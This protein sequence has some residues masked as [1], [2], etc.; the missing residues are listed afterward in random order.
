ME[1]HVSG[2]PSGPSNFSQTPLKKSPKFCS[3]RFSASYFIWVT[4]LINRRQ[5]KMCEIYPSYY[6]GI[7]L[8]S[9]MG[10]IQAVVVALCMERD[11]SR[12]KLGW[13]IRLLTVFYS[14]RFNG[15]L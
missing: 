3:F 11:W 14:V 2:P 12:W 5:A 6:S 8:M 15:K 1:N 9:I 4:E 7:A 13:N 10:T